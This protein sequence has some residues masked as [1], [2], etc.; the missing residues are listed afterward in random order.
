MPQ[1]VEISEA[2]LDALRLELV[3]EDARLLSNQFQNN[4]FIEI[5][6][7]RPKSDIESLD[8]LFEFISP[9][10]DKEN[11]EEKTKKPHYLIFIVDVLER[12]EL[13][14]HLLKK[15]TKLEENNELHDNFKAFENIYEPLKSSF[16][17]MAN[18]YPTLSVK[19]FLSSLEKELDFT[20]GQTLTREQ[21]E[22]QIQRASHGIQTYYPA[23]SSIF[24]PFILYPTPDEKTHISNHAL[25]TAAVWNVRMWYP[26]RLSSPSS[27]NF[28][29]R[30]VMRDPLLANKQELKDF[31]TT[32]D[33][34]IELT[35]LESFDTIVGYLK[36]LYHHSSVRN[37]ARPDTVSGGHDGPRNRYRYVRV[38]LD[39]IVE[40]IYTDNDEELIYVAQKARLENDDSNSDDVDETELITNEFM[41]FEDGDNDE[42]KGNLERSHYLSKYA[43]AHLAQQNQFFQNDLSLSEQH[44]LLSAIFTSIKD[45]QK[46]HRKEEYS[47]MAMIIVSYLLGTSF[48]RPFAIKL[49]KE[50]QTPSKHAI[51]LN[52]ELTNV[53]IPLNY[54]YKKAFIENS[55]QNYKTDSFITLPLPKLITTMLRE[56]IKSWYEIWNEEVHQVLNKHLERHLNCTDEPFKNRVKK[57]LKQADLD[58]RVTPHF[59]EKTIRHSFYK[60][61]NGDY[62]TLYIFSGVSKVLGST[63]KHYTTSINKHIFQVYQKAVEARFEQT[64]EIPN[65]ANQK[66]FIGYGNPVRPIKSVV[67]NELNHMADWLS[68]SFEIPIEETSTQNLILQLNIMT[69]YFETYS[70]FFNGIRDITNPYIYSQQLDSTNSTVIIDKEIQNGFNTRKIPMLK[71]L[72]D[73]QELFEERVEGNIDRLVR[74][75]FA[76][77]VDFFN[78]QSEGTNPWR[79]LRTSN[80]KFPGLFLI[81]LKPYKRK[82]KPRHRIQPYTRHRAKAIYKES[83]TSKN[84]LFFSITVNANR[85]FLRSSLIEKGLN[86]E[87]VDEFMGHRHFGTEST[88]PSS[89]HNPQDYLHSTRAMLKLISQDFGCKLPVQWH[90]TLKEKKGR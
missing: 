55:G 5:L 12:L 27:I 66:A 87:Y 50:E 25:I 80:I 76:R 17:S 24:E 85:H 42:R 75:K 40:S 89:L 21:K 79:S 26:K 67:V 43:V 6:Q 53:S 65:L 9:P 18:D 68:E 35:G 4:P 29:L 19:S 83:N 39:E 1:K 2:K 20:R 84:P 78:L 30:K 46:K 8:K 45:T 72:I 52:R 57:I 60:H 22:R 16:E 48:T 71:K 44:R 33:L 62:W 59:L 64:I 63:Q 86:P 69:L 90:A 47:A 7:S 34:I 70:S 74:R 81:D 10:L 32:E 82:T 41:I 56:V 58:E 37:I 3:R 11:A 51:S 28:N 77:K 49:L 31:E 36:K 88:N 38:S 15:N 73:L 23:Y 13:M 54:P 14:G 61:S